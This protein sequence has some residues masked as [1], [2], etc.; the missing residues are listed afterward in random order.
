M[1]GKTQPFMFSVW[2]SDSKLSF[3][4]RDVYSSPVWVKINLE[5]SIIIVAPGLTTE[6]F[7]IYTSAAQLSMCS[8]FDD[9]VSCWITF[10]T[11]IGNSLNQFS[12][13]EWIFKSLLEA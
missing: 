11:Y 2:G 7:L 6:L 9:V 8:A 3:T 13:L 5:Y 4:L 12:Q 10:E 1:D